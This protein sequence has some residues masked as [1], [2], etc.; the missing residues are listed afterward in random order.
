[1]SS[2]SD[3]AVVKSHDG[4]S[5]KWFLYRDTGPTDP[6]LI[7]RAKKAINLVNY[8]TGCNQRTFGQNLKFPGFIGVKGLFVSENLKVFQTLVYVMTYIYVDIFFYAN[9]V[10]ACHKMLG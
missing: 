7:R 2:S 9:F 10:Q 6:S 5:V 4:I 1:M 8:G 3:V